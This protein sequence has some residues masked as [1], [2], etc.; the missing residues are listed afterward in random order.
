MNKQQSQLI[1]IFVI[2]LKRSLERKEFIK[3]Q[4]DDLIQQT[5]K[6][7][8][9]EFFVAINGKETPN[10]PLFNK[11][12]DSL[13][14]ERKGN[15]MNL[16]Q[17]GCF[18]SHYLLWEKCLTLKQPII[19]LEDDA[20]IHDSFIDVYDF[21]NSSQNNFEF[22]WLSPPAPVNRGQKGKLVFNIPNISHNVLKYYKGWGNATGYFITP[23]AAKKL[24]EYT[25]TWIYD[26]DITMDR[27][28]ENNLHYLAI[29]PACLEPNFSMESNIPVDKGKKERTLLI[30]IKREFYK[31]ID[32]I[33][34][35]IFDLRNK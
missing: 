9:Y 35:F 28:W 25:T 2:N 3:K 17:L 18:A 34:K 19:I 10:H 20:I 6:S 8:N 7:I 11:Y 31:T 16:S 22:F 1:P 12:N 30:K 27:Y 26:A 33:N 32:N 23:Q 4:F 5:Q 13:R 24:L 21:I 14:F 29:S 15:R